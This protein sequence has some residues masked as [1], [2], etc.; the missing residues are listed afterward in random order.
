MHAT[1]DL[2]KSNLSDIGAVYKNI[3]RPQKKR[4]KRGGGARDKKKNFDFDEMLCA[5]R[6]KSS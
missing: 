5:I 3:M 6:G 4:W 2:H 1:V